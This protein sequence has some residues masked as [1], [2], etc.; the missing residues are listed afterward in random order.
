VPDEVFW[1]KKPNMSNLEEFGK[2]CWVLQQNRKNSKLIPKSRQCIFVGVADGT[3]GYRYY[4]SNTHQIL[5]SWNMI[6]EVEGEKS[7]DVEITHP[8]PLE[9]E[10]EE[11]N[12]QM[13]GGDRIQAQNAPEKETHHASKS[14]SKIPIPQEQLT[15]ITTQPLI[16]YRLLNNPNSHGPKEWQHQVL[17]V[18]E[19]GFI[20]VDYAMIGASLEDDLLSV[21]EAKGRP[22]WEK[23]KEGMDAKISQLTKQGTFKL[24]DLPSDQQAIVSKWVYC[25]KCDHIGMI[26]KHKARLMA[27]GCSQIP[28]IDFVETFAPVMWLET[29]HLLIALTMKLGLVIHLVNIDTST[30]HLELWRYADTFCI[31]HYSSA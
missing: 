8:M 25:I 1:G 7:Y 28:G 17:A 13:S 31:A 23:W 22:D 16:N 3:R 15:C 29:F 14:P 21:K 5:T 6:F 27:K 26:M 24:V 30:L 4:N 18:E 20:M 2:T 10:S 11:N 12:K 19:S 9:G